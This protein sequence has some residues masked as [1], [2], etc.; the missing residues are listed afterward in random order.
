VLQALLVQ[1]VTQALP[2]AHMLEQ[3]A[4]KMAITQAVYLL[5]ME[6]VMAQG[7]KEQ[8]LV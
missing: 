4:P 5:V 8:V 7:L 6:Q 1:R 3:L 2:E